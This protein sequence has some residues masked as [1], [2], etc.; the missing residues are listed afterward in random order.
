MLSLAFALTAAVPLKVAPAD[1]VVM[2]V[3]GGVVSVTLTVRLI[4]VVCV[5]APEVPVIV[6]VEVPVVAEA[7]AVR[8][9]VEDPLPFAGGVTEVGLKDA[10]TP[11]GKPDAESETAELKLLVLVTVIVLLPLFPWLIVSEDGEAESEKSGVGDPPQVGNL[12]E[13]ILVAQLKAPLEGRYSV[14]YQ[15]VQSSE[16]STTMLE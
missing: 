13:T 3:V 16:G 5:V 14:V 1:G 9:S 7:E 11:L 12:N 10:V 15:N 4:V 6:T 2:E 8:V